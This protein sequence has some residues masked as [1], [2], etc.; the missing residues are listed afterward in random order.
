MWDVVFWHS[1]DS[2][3]A[4]GNFV[5]RSRPRTPLA[6]DFI[7]H[8]HRW[9]WA[10]WSISKRQPLISLSEFILAERTVSLCRSCQ[11]LAHSI[12]SFKG[13]KARENRNRGPEE[14]AAIDLQED[15]DEMISL[16]ALH[17][18]LH[19]QTELYKLSLRKYIIKWLAG[20][21]QPVRMIH[22]QTTGLNRGLLFCSN[23]TMRRSWYPSQHT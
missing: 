21:T 15:P 22:L 1:S 16:W 13:C 5:M 19:F 9:L 18:F 8:A 6:L 17:S 12:S 3:L 23:L 20:W 2:P 14:N 10:I 7:L 11:P 4:L